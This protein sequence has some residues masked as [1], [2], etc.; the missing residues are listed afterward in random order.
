[1]RKK[2]HEEYFGESLPETP[3]W[4]HAG[5]SPEHYLTMR[6]F[7]RPLYGEKVIGVTLLYP[8]IQLHD[9]WDF[10]PHM[11]ALGDFTVI[12]IRRNP[13]VCYVSWKQAEQSGIWVRSEQ[14][15]NIPSIPTPLVLTDLT[16][17]ISFC[18][19][20]AAWECRI[21]NTCSDRLEV[22]YK[23]IVLHY[24]DV[25]DEVFSFLNLSPAPKVT[26]GIQRLKNRSL[27]ERVTNLDEVR[28]K[29]PGDVREFF[30]HDLF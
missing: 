8:E 30:D 21:A 15:P 14:D 17:L 13:L 23:E 2:Q 29:V 18:R 19:A 6:V 1:M 24:R 22:T 11:T 7:D 25:I 28:R 16:E 10:L 5:M 4:C 9:L 3:D 20:H 26:C 27:R 12:H